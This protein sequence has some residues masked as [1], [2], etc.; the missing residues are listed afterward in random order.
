MEMNEIFICSVAAN[1]AKSLWKM[2]NLPSKNPVAGETHVI[3]S[4]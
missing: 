3:N 2:N 4:L 1:D